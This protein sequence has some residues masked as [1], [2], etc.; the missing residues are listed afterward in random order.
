[1]D[2]QVCINTKKTDKY[3]TASEILIKTSVYDWI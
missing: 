3:I 1:M 2:K